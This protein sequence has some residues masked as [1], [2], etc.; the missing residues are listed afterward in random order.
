ML[1]E[2]KDDEKNRFSPGQDVLSAKGNIKTKMSKQKLK[3][4]EDL[5]REASFMSKICCSHSNRISL[6]KAPKC[7]FLDKDRMPNSMF[8]SL[9]WT[10]Q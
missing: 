9:L 8:S 6:T 1:R 3:E 5:T 4:N 7:K 2:K 10:A